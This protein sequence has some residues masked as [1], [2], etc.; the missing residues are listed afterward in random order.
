MNPHKKK[1][2]LIA[3]QCKNVGT[4]NK[5]GPN[6]TTAYY[7]W[8]VIACRNVKYQGF[9]PYSLSGTLFRSNMSLI[10]TTL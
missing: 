3:G 8:V 10:H 6:I 5:N 2:F 9:P 7:S 4:K 1:V